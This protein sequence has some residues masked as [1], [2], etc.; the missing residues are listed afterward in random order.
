MIKSPQSTIKIPFIARPPK[1][2]EFET[3][4]PSRSDM[5]KITGFIQQYPTDGAQPTQRTEVY[6]GYDHQNLYVVWLCFDKEPG[7]IRAHMARR[8]VIFD[9]DYVEITLDT[10]HDQRRGLV[11]STNP[12]GIQADGIWSENSGNDT[13]WDT[14]WNTWGKLTQQ[15][16]VVIQAIPFHNLRFPKG[17]AEPIWGFT[18]DRQIPRAD[19][20]DYWP[21][22]SAK[23]SGLL[24]QEANLSGLEG[25]EP[26]KNMQFNPYVY[27]QTFHTIN[28]D[29]S[30]NPVFQSKTFDGKAGLD[31]K[32]IFQDKW[33]LDTTIEPDFSQIESD[34]PQNTVNQRF[35]VF[36]PEKRP[37][38]LENSNFFETLNFYQQNRLVFTRNIVDPQFGARLT[39]KDGPWAVGLLVADDRS[40]G[41]DVLPGDPL[42]GKR[43][44]F[45]VGR[46]AYDVGKNS[47]VGLIYTDREFAGDF[48]R[49]GGFD[50]NFKLNKNWNLVYRGVVSSTLDNANKNG[51]AFGSN[52]DGSVV[53]NGERFTLVAQYQDITG[54]FRA[55]LGFIHRTDIRRLNGYY[56]FY[57]KPKKNKLKMILY[58]PELSTDRT[59]DHTGLG[60]EYNVNG[61]WVFGFHRNTI[62]APVVGIES[63]TLRPQDFTGLTFDKKFTQ[64][65]AGIVFR[66]S[67]LRS[68]LFNA[69]IF[70]QGAVNIVVPAGQLP[71]EGDETT[72]NAGLTYKPINGL[73]IDNTYIMDRVRHNPLGHAVFDNHIIRSKWNYQFTPAFSLRFIA[74]WNGL[75]ANQQFSSLQTTK[76]MNFDFLFTY[77]PHPGT[78]IYAG[79]NSNL[80]NINPE[81]CVKVAGQ[82]D[83]NGNGLIHGPG[84]LLND[85]RIAFVKVSYLWHP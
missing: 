60:I 43:A 64:D 82:C 49:V 59:Y 14:V 83:P 69:N 20:G 15:G 55:L 58:G 21:R 56:H 28:Q 57:W 18:L 33:V 22:V 74:Q 78:A 54:G 10:F 7:K 67:P 32:I 68:L 8:E 53:G 27:A 84:G 50:F 81:L 72:I 38:F 76:N 25:I 31:S 65:F 85:G 16:Y 3:M 62:I 70:R 51:Y 61:D 24:N 44:Y 40:P 9:D 48:N 71:N 80:E 29:V 42:F 79:Y 19:E 12:M 23:V 46:V 26:S 5:V 1:M 35:A 45:A 73:Q 75:L 36:F 37:F 63:D 77:L 6:M 39:G 11:F 17:Q 34:Q 13:S 2:E 47:T 30:T 4:Q 66:S 52:H 41:E